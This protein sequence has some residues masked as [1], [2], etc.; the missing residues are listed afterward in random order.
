MC[1]TSPPGCVSMSAIPCISLLIAFG[2]RVTCVTGTLLFPFLRKP[3]P[4]Q[5]FPDVPE[6]LLTTCMKPVLSQESR[7]SCSLCSKLDFQRPFPLD[8]FLGSWP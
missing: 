4:R 2:L 8:V 6:M 7:L 3:N 1:A 5:V